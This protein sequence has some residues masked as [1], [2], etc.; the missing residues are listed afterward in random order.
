MP[1]R[2]PNHHAGQ[3]DHG[4]QVGDGH[5]AVE[6]VGDVPGQGQVHGGAHHN[7]DDE[8]DLV[9][10]DGLGA[11]DELTGTGAVQRPA[12]HRGVG[13]QGQAHGDQQGAELVAEDGAEGGHVQAG[14]ALDA[15]VQ[16]Q[17]SALGGAE[18]GQTGQGADDD[19]VH[20]DLEDAVDTLLHRVGLGGG[21]V[22]HRRGAQAGLVGEH[23]ALHAPG[24]AQEHGAAGT[25]GD[26]GG[27]EGAHKDVMED[28]GQGVGVVDNHHQGGDDVDQSHHGDQ[29]LGDG[30]QAL[31]AAEEDHGGEGGQGDAQHQV[32][33]LLGL[34]AE[35][36]LEGHDHV[37]DGGDDV[38]HLH[39]V[40]DAEGSQGGEDTE[41]DAQPLPVLAQAVLDVVHGAAHPVAVLVPLTELHGQG[42]LGVLG[43][44]TD[45][46]SDPQPEDGAGAAQGD[47]GGDTGDVAGAH[48]ACQGGG[49]GLE[50]GHLTL[51]GCGFVED[52]ADGVLHGVAE[53]AE[54]HA[55]GAQGHQDARAHQQDQHGNA[56]Y[57]SVDRTVNA[58]NQCHAYLSFFLK[59]LFT[60]GLEYRQPEKTIGAPQRIA[61][62]LS[63][64]EMGRVRRG[65]SCQSVLLPESVALR[66]APSAP[67]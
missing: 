7:D 62:L 54:L 43:T 45:E 30:A 34:L 11:E 32:H 63:K 49:H 6:G 33:D 35:A 20:E 9:G 38:A 15:V 8:D 53:L 64:A 19:G 13:E 59:F 36:G 29:L 31:D 66:L 23:A 26:A 10:P 1:L 52:L 16:V 27:G 24:D 21:G 12:Q 41:Q 37:V 65:V 42:N 18:D 17:A 25:A 4:D 51:A 58:F 48:G 55:T 60:R 61:A 22:G 5:E 3:G 39:G 44:H 2:F 47:G 57:E 50:G 14:V 40:A 46:G 28:G 67:V 56:P